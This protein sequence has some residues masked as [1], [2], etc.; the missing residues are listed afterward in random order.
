MQS[1]S[2]MARI[3]HA[4]YYKLGTI[5]STEVKHRPS[6]VWRSIC[7]TRALVHMGLRWKIGNGESI[8]V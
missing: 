5:L 3:Y 7:E 2:V 8:R 4:K 6:F 1:D